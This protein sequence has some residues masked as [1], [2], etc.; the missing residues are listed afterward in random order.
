MTDYPV[1]KIEDLKVGDVVVVT[2][3]VLQSK[4]YKFDTVTR[5]TPT[6][7]IC[8]KNSF[9][10]NSLR[11]VG[12]S[13]DWYPLRLMSFNRGLMSVQEAKDINEKVRQE[14]KHGDLAQKLAD[15][16]K[17]DWMKLS[18]DELKEILEKLNPSQ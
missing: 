4:Y 3:G 12:D 9:M 1:V 5:L 18:V 7:I 15:V 8:E 16:S 11:R 14:S 17:T 10:K 13:S 6:R 2:G